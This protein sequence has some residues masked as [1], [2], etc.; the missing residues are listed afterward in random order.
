MTIVAIGL[1]GTVCGIKALH[2]FLWGNDA[3][4]VAWLTALLAAFTL[5]LTA[6]WPVI[7]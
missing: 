6:M 4:G 1:L 3:S 7:A 5:W 2:A